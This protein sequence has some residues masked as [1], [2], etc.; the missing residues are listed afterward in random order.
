MALAVEVSGT[1]GG[2]APALIGRKP[3]SLCRRIL[4]EDHSGLKSRYESTVGMPSVWHL[5]AWLVW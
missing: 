5:P 4:L 2:G 1:D 3:L